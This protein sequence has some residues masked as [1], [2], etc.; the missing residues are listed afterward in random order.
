MTL[1]EIRS[2]TR[3]LIGQQ[4]ASASEHT[5]AEV[6]VAI[7]LGYVFV[8]SAAELLLDIHTRVSDTSQGGWY[9][10]PADTVMVRRVYY[11]GRTEKL[12]ERTIDELD[13]ED[14]GWTTRVCD[15]GTVPSKWAPMGQMIRL[16]P[17]DIVNNKTIEVWSIAAPPPL[18]T[19]SS[20]P[21]IPSAYHEGICLAAAGRLMSSDY[22]NRA[23]IS[24]AR[25][26]L[27][28]QLAGILA[29]AQMHRDREGEP[30]ALRDV[31]DFYASEW[32]P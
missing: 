32:R 13:R 29:L 2:W 9:T 22:T 20:I 5:D 11:E 4:D 21:V 31:R 28:P 30:K 27:A 25:E 7:G 15:A 19:P 26:I 23:G 14:T 16:V 1:A 17:K 10:K 24:Y 12:L 18:T 8:V 6:D 3:T